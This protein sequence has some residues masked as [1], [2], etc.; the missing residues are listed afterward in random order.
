MYF[1]IKVFNIIYTYGIHLFAF[2]IFF[3]LSTNLYT[4]LVIREVK[5]VQFFTFFHLFGIFWS[6]SKLT[7]PIPY[8][9]KKLES[10]ICF[11]TRE[12]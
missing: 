12:T 2:L 8:F 1:L 11:L 6:V 10:F 3:S 4:E 9:R 7:L 5:F